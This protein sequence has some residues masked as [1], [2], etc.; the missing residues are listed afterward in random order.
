MTNGRVGIFQRALAVDQ[1]QTFD[2]FARDYADLG[3]RPQSLR[4]MYDKLR[5]DKI[6]LSD[7]YQVAIDKDPRHGYAGTIIWHLSIKR[8][9]KEPIMDWRDLQ[10]IKSQL[11]G[12][13]AEAIQLFPAE[14]RK[15]DTSNQYHLWVFMKAGS[16]RLPRLPVGWTTEMVIDEAVT[17]KAKQR[18][19]D[20]EKDDGE[21]ADGTAH[22]A[23]R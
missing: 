17:G 20:R 19:Y 5:R 23:V 18:S 1:M 15:V 7:Q 12:D 10:A 3:L 2:E 21:P 16:L 6:Y 14:S 9:D 22:P 8:I 11:C 4:A 13:E